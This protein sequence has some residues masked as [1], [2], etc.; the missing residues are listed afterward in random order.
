LIRLGVGAAVTPPGKS[1]KLMPSSLAAS[2]W[3]MAG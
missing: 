3:M 1:G 2:L